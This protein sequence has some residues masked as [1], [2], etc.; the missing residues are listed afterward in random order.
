MAQLWCFV[1]IMPAIV[2]SGVAQIK[3]MTS[4]GWECK[5]DGSAESECDLHG[6]DYQ[7]CYTTNGHWDYCASNPYTTRGWTCN[8]DGSE[9]STCGCHLHSKDPEDYAWCYTSNGEWDYCVPEVD[10]E[11]GFMQRLSDGNFLTCDTEACAW[12]PDP[13]QLFR[14]GAGQSCQ[15]R[16]HILTE[17]GEDTTQCLSADDSKMRLGACDDDG[18]SFWGYDGSELFFS[19]FPT[20]TPHGSCAQSDGSL[21]PCTQSHESVHWPVSR[22]CK[23]N[24]TAISDVKCKSVSS[25][26][27]CGASFQQGSTAGGHSNHDC[28]A[29]K[30][31]AGS[32]TECDFSFQ[33]STQHTLSTSF[34]SAT[35]IMIGTEF[36][37]GVDFLVEEKATVKFSVTETLTYGKTKSTSTTSSVT[38]GCKATIKAGT[39]ESATAN[40]FT[41]TLVGDFTAKVTTTYDC[42]WKK[43][44]V[45]ET[46]GSI[47]ITNVPTQSMDGSCKTTAEVCPHTPFVV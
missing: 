28:N 29:C 12:K 22:D 33:V 3:T 46:S 15:R 16:F 30:A 8:D 1:L 4:W 35:A 39:A 25:G 7:W 17:D 18:A 19:P 36:E 31:A 43:K 10:D 13:T 14:V 32:T 42:P 26:G 41:G 34:S 38:G 47:T 24:M 27:S 23:P 11:S 21:A 44:Q 9:E 45:S 37:V 6:E 20:F 40:F 2:Y 5:D